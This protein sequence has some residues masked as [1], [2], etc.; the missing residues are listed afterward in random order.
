MAK[1]IP[2]GR[3][4][5]LKSAATGAAALA[6]IPN[7]APAQQGGRGGRGGRGG[8]QAQPDPAAA[9]RE[10]G[11]VRPA[12]VSRVIEQPGSDYM[13]D[14]VKALGI[15]YVAANP[16]TSTGGLHESIIN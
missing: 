13:V 12:P 5:F 14:V 9:A 7:I 8:A 16:G 4:G 10:A 15:E 1:K 11:N 3:R 2:V 6:T